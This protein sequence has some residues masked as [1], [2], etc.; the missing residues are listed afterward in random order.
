MRSRPTTSFP[1]AGRRS[2]GSLSQ[3]FR[4]WRRQPRKQ[5]ARLFW[6]LLALVILL[7]TLLVGMAICLLFF[8]LPRM[9]SWTSWLAGE[10]PSR[11]P[12]AACLLAAGMLG[13]GLAAGPR[14]PR[15]ARGLYAAGL[16]GYAVVVGSAAAVSSWTQ[17]GAAA[18]LTWT[19]LLA[20]ALGL[21]LDWT[22]R[23]RVFLLAGALVSAVLLLEADCW[24]TAAGPQVPGWTAVLH[25][26]GRQAAG[27]LLLLSGYAALALAGGL[28]NLTL[29]RMLLA[30][31]RARSIR[32][33][34]DGGFRALRW[35][36]V[37]LAAGAAL[38]GVPG[39]RSREACDVA[40][41]L[42]ALLLLHARFAGWMQD[43]GLALGCA[44]GFAALVLAWCGTAW[45]GGANPA[46]RACFGWLCWAAL[47]TA[48]LALHAT[49]R[50]WFTSPDCPKTDLEDL[51]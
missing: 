24:P 27:G 10:G 36:V 15:A 33:L 35:G 45:L 14:R 5:S 47:A 28:G 40:V 13:I 18:G 44:A 32:E 11:R 6:G 4:V 9:P 1:G 43:L 20:G 31:H 29:L 51:P 49:H 39:W 2:R 25:G 16:L 3:R 38:G 30:P 8:T 17:D 41:S 42:A 19:A 34:S 37:L 46:A 26:G 21:L 48:S 23:S 7:D 22:S 50:W 12:W